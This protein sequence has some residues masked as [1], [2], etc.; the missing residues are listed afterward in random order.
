VVTQ[1]PVKR[2][3]RKKSMQ[4][5]LDEVAFGDGEMIDDEIDITGSGDV[6][7]DVGSATNKVLF[8]G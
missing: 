1:K 7:G 8:F 5:K 6:F 4:Q 2:Q 3:I